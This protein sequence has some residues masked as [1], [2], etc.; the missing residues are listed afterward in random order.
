MLNKKAKQVTPLIWRWSTLA[1]LWQP[2]IQVQLGAIKIHAQRGLS[3]ASARV[4]QNKVLSLWEPDSCM[5]TQSPCS[6]WPEM[7]CLHNSLHWSWDKLNCVLE[8]IPMAPRPISGRRKFIH[9]RV[10]FI[11]IFSGDS[12]LFSEH[13]TPTWNSSKHCITKSGLSKKLGVKSSHTGFW[14]IVNTIFQRL[15]D[16][17]LS[18]LFYWEP[19]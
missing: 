16:N 11:T 6:V 2:Y 8:H 1:C 4:L 19:L 17:I 14:C 3:N 9:V 7:L 10:N 13:F 12:F 15:N 5:Y 18:R